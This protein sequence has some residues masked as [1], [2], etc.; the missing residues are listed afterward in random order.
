MQYMKSAVAC[1]DTTSR[2]ENV[3]VQTPHPGNLSFTPSIAT[4][5]KRRINKTIPS[6][7]AKKDGNDRLWLL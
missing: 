3:P 4:G 7:R 6:I 2:G 1:V 5:C